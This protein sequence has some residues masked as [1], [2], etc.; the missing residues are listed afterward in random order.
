MHL[1]L[2]GELTRERQRATRR[3][4]GANFTAVVVVAVGSAVLVYWF[5]GL[6]LPASVPWSIV[7]WGLAGLAGLFGLM[8]MLAGVPMVFESDAEL[9]ERDKKRSDRK[10]QRMDKRSKAPRRG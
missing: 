2:S 6:A 10:A 9:E 4:R 8:L 3:F 5:V 7:F 1:L